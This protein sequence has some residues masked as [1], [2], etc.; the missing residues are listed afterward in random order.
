MTTDMRGWL[1]SFPI[2][3]RMS[4]P[5]RV[6]SKSCRYAYAP[7]FLIFFSKAFR[8]AFLKGCR[9]SARSFNFKVLCTALSDSSIRENGL[10]DL[11]GSHHMFRRPRP[12]PGTRAGCRR[13]L[14]RR[15][16]STERRPAIQDLALALLGRNL[17]QRMM[18]ST[19]NSRIA[20]AVSG[21]KFS[22]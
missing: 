21:I 10:M 18:Q 8:F 16:R 5:S 4:F 20:V 1:L 2:R 15:Y 6:T 12:V 9:Q 3:S 17:S 7:A 11:T 22:E 14:R 19:R 13:L